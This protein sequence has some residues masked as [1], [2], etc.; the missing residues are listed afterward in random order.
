MC[1]S[2]SEPLKSAEVVMNLFDIESY[3]QQLLH[4][5]NMC[6]LQS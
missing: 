1:T 3:L 2:E 4:I 5:S 6:K